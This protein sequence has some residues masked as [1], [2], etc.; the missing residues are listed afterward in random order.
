MK[1]GDQYDPECLGCHVTGFG[2]PAG[3]GS[4][5]VA[6]GTRLRDV[7]CE[8]CHGSGAIHAAYESANTGKGDSPHISR[9]VAEKVCK[10][11]HDTYQSPDFDYG[12]YLQKGGAHMGPKAR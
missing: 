4:P 7:T 8:S 10:G 11:C 12:K 9:S 3:Y 6:A 1:T 2:S 5:C